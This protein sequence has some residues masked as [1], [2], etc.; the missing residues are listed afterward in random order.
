MKPKFLMLIF[1]LLIFSGERLSGQSTNDKFNVIP[2]K[3]GNS[4]LFGKDIIINNDSAQ[5]QRNVVLCSAFNGWLYAA[6]YYVEPSDNHL[7]VMMV[8]KST[9]SGMTW[10]NII[11]F[12]LPFEFCKVLTIDI[13]VTGNEISN[14]KLL[15]GFVFSYNDP[16][17]DPSYGILAIYRYNGET[18][19]YEDALPTGNDVGYFSFATDYSFPANGSN[20][21]SFSLI[22]S[23]NYSG[24]DSLI[25]K[26][27]SDGGL[28]LGSSQTITT[29]PMHIGKVALNYGRSL[30]LNSGRYFAA[31]EEKATLTSNFGHIYTAHTEPNF[32]SPWTTP[33]KLDSIDPSALN[34]AKNPS[35]ACQYSNFDNDSSNLTEVVLFDKYISAENRYDIAG[36]CNKRAAS[37]NHFTPFTLNLSTDSRQQPSINFNPYDSSFMVTYYDST[38]NKLSFV[39]HN[40]N[41]NIPDSWQVLTSGYNDSTNIDAPYPKVVLNMNLQKG[42]CV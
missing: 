21:Q 10:T 23:K 42:A 6:Y 22:Y 1:L 35:I 26:S 40:F 36:L 31:W 33:I 18:S 17:S 34:K 32:N 37:S 3:P 19:V 8:M 9:D 7:P 13:A 25:F 28:T 5:N 15:L 38:T 11:S 39:K 12:A 14:L 20:P 29:T 16:S 27:S 41:M 2:L 30:V 4:I 24:G